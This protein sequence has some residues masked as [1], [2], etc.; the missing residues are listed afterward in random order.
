MWQVG[1]RTCNVSPGKKRPQVIAVRLTEWK[2][3]LTRSHRP[4][5]Q[6]SSET[7]KPKINMVNAKA[8]TA[9]VVLVPYW[10]LTGSIFCWFSAYP[11]G[12]FSCTT[13]QA[14]WRR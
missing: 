6:A 8:E 14:T 5:V 3:Q 9:A 11:A 1:E 13:C 4:F 12:E 7:L 2:R 10:R